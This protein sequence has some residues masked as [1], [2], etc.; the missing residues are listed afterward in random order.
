M[1]LVQ[2]ALV[3]PLGL[4]M[5]LATPV[6]A[7]GQHVV[8]PATMAAAV[9]QRA[10]QTDAERAEVRTALAQPRVREMAGRLGIDLE[11]ADAAV[12]TMADS[13]LAR[14]A[15]AARQVN[16][17]LAGGA[18]TVVISTTTIIIA[19]LVLIV[20]IVAVK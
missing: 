13:D 17:S 5:A 4:L 6:F 19:L 18:S 14:A 1:R 10:A 7:D 9:S 3:L 8:S 16:Q 11:R 20:I 15:D 2:R 12:S